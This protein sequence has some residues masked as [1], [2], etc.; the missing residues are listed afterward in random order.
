MDSGPAATAAWS[1]LSGPGNVVFSNLASPATSVTFDQPGNYVLRL[2]ATNSSGQTFAD[3]SDTIFAATLPPPIVTVSSP[4]SPVFLADAAHALRLTASVDTGGVP[5]TP[6]F[7]W[8]QLSGPGTVSFGDP[9][10]ADTSATF[11]A[12]GMYLLRCTATNAG[13]TATA[14][15][16][17]AVA[18]PAS[19]TFRQGENSYN[20]TA[21]FLRSD[22]TAWNSGAR[23]Q[24]LVGRNDTA[25]KLFRSVFSFPLTGVPSSATL[26]DITL[27]LWT[28]PTDAGTGSVSTIEL[29]GLSATPVEGIGTGS[30]ATDG[31][32]TGATWINRTQ[33]TAWSTPGGDFN[34]TVLSSVPGFNTTSLGVQKTFPSSAAFLAAAQT[35][36][37]SG[38]PLDLM[39][40]AP[41]SE[42]GTTANFTRFVSDDHATAT[43]RPRLTLTWNYEPAAV[44]DPGP[45]PAA[46]TG[47]PA[48]LTATVSGAT[49][50]TWSLV[51][52]PG[53]AVFE[54]PA[55]SATT[56]TFNQPGAYLLKLAATNNAAEVSRI[57]QIHVAANP[58]YFAD[59]QTI[60]W[61]GATDSE[62]IGMDQDP[63]Q[64]GN[65]NLLEWALNLDAKVADHFNPIFVIDGANLQYTYTR[66]KTAAGEA[67]F[68]VLWSD[69]LEDDWS[70]EN[71]SAETP[72]SETDTTRTVM[73]SV[74]VTSEKRFLRVR[75][76]KP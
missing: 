50:T 72:V 45:A 9:S 69:T 22:T 73:V 32:G 60:T 4:S 43:Q 6:S 74:P 19:A 49:S 5:G 20:H 47:E 56:V 16:T 14:D 34:V 55:Q 27:D 31:A 33:T 42:S 71:V 66:R 17:V 25:A 67:E 61:P 53:S 52:G 64:D 26:T 10:A 37:A 3:L 51:S 18:T 48:T 70:S 68:Q 30:L 7:V 59:W 75:V 38:S 1:K 65:S 39:L 57:L 36:V 2:T 76:S 46:I 28:H 63:D 23:D 40:L 58:A 62:I 29:R 8:S 15:V 35:A 11:S 41:A 12:A 21:T 44:I 13:G 24:V 54:N